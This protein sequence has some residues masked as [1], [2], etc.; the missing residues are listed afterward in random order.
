M[1]RRILRPVGYAILALA[2]AAPLTGQGS[3]VYNQS[4]C[5]SAA[6]GAA[7]ASPCRDASSIYYS[8]GALALQP[9]AVS[10]GFSAIY[11][12]G[13]FTY[14]QS[15][16]E[17]E[18]EAATPIVPH[19]YGSYSM[20]RWAVGFGV[21]A[22]YGL[23]IEWPED[24]EGRFV[25][26]KTQ[27]RGIY[28]QPTIAYELIPGKLGVGAGPQ[29]VL[30]GLELNQS[31]ELA[32]ANPLLSGFPLGTDAVRAKLEGSGTGFGGQVGLYYNV[33]DRLSIGA[34][35]MHS[36]EVDL[37]GD[38]T[39]EQVD[40]TGLPESVAAVIGQMFEPGGALVDQ[41]V[42]AS[43]TFPPQAVVGVSFA[44]S[45]DLTISGDYQ[46]TGWSTFDQIV[47]DFE[48][49]P[50]QTLTLQ[51]NDAH[52]FRTGLKYALSPRLEARGGFVYNTAATPDQTVTP[53]LPEAERHLYGAGLGYEM[54]SFRAD[55]FYNY[56]NQADRRGRVRSAIQGS[57][58]PG[59]DPA[60]LNVG[61]YSSTAHL[62]GLT[63]SYSPGTSW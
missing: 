1:G 26:Y 2:A 21:W 57:E 11:N 52:T 16:V 51:Y 23:G 33:S 49:A 44:A 46:W 42:S 41:A 22:P 47:A 18:R 12:T 28:L 9:T 54:G 60:T 15:G 61:V 3:S 27:L 32:L 48:F 24:F 7:V 56:V 62:F 31:Q 35:Y 10:A 29:I 25:S 19:A 38:G 43:L 40:I 13:A 53:I 17:V 39:F 6:G 14:D 37:E 45:P 63:L 50:D 20:D 30:G 59:F 36:V 5:V 34:R 8:P 4:A 58:A 55:V